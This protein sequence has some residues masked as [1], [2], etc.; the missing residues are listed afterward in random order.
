[1][2]MTSL[3]LCRIVLVRIKSKIL[4]ILRGK[5]ILQTC[6]LQELGVME[7]SPRILSIT[8]CPLDQNDLHLSHLDYIHA[9]S[10]PLRKSL[11]PLQY[12][13]KA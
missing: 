10:R 2:E 13:L 9:F 8:V 1:M 6:A 12:F 11:I 3:P 5:R 4:V 7:G